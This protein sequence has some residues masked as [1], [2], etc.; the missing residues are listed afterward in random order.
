MGKQLWSCH[1]DGHVPQGLGGWAQSIPGQHLGMEGE[2]EGP[3]GLSSGWE[4]TSSS[5]HGEHR[6][7]YQGCLSR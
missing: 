5:K 3:E 6:Q 1:E 2:E 7:E 4:E